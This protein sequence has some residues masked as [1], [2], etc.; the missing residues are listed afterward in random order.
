MK[1]LWQWLLKHGWSRAD[2]LLGQYQ[3]EQAASTAMTLLD[4]VPP[5][6]AQLLVQQA[7]QRQPRLLQDQANA[8]QRLAVASCEPCKSPSGRALML[9]PS[10]LHLLYADC[11]VSKSDMTTLHIRHAYL[12][13]S[14]GM[15]VA[16]SKASLQKM[17]DCEARPIISTHALISQSK[18]LLIVVHGLFVAVAGHHED[19]RPESMHADMDAGRLMRQEPGSCAVEPP[20]TVRSASGTTPQQLSAWEKRQYSMA[21]EEE[22]QTVEL[23]FKRVRLFR[24]S[25]Q[26][27]REGRRLSD[28]VVEAYCYLLQV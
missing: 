12:A 24:S 9:K 13:S 26:C 2:I 16:S 22:L 3:S 6:Q 14:S 10:N 28:E 27:L 5:T 8:I 18:M 23:I 20:S 4:G 19:S 1:A 17:Q 25:I 15:T 11:H 7:M 21:M